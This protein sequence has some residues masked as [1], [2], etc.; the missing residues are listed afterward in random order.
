MFQYF[1]IVFNI[2]LFLDAFV[3]LQPFIS[4]KNVIEFYAN[5]SFKF[6]PYGN[7]NWRLDLQRI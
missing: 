1:S 4:K 5:Y 3:D 6:V 2:V 7:R